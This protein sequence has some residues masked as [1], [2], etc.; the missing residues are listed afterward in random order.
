[1]RKDPHGQQRDGAFRVTAATWRLGTVAEIV[2][3]TPHAVSMV[4][5][6]PGWPGHRAGQHVDVRLDATG[7]SLVPRSCPI[8]SAPEDGYVML[9]VERGPDG[10]VSASRAGELRTGDQLELRGPIGDFVWDDSAR[11]PALLVAG[12]WGIVP[13]RSMLRH[14]QAAPAGVAVRL[15]Y[16]ARSLQDVIYREELMR[17]A[18]YDEVD[19][20]FA[21]T[22]EWPQTWHGHRGR[23]DGR[24]L[25]EVSW[26]AS[27]KPRTVICGPTAFAETVAS[28]LVAQGQH[29]DQIRQLSVPDRTRGDS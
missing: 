2:P 7:R 23:V 29:G 27:D 15:L 17:F 22:R 1:L 20:R 18:A 8:A 13:V 28:A 14:I 16:S 11:E 21:L 25:S 24:L 19:I 10:D 4:L 12:G 26:P 6:L 5:D 3:E 9:T